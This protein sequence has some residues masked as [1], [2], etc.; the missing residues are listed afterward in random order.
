[1]YTISRFNIYFLI[2]I[3]PL[4]PIIKEH[5]L[6]LGNIIEGGILLG[7]FLN[8]I[9]CKSASGWKISVHKKTFLITLLLIIETIFYLSDF[10]DTEVYDVFSASRVFLFYIFLIGNLEKLISEDNIKCDTIAKT[11]A[12]VSILFAV[13]AI[14]QFVIPDVFLSVHAPNITV[15]LRSKSDFIAFSFFNRVFS[16]LND[17]NIFGV[18]S[19]F[20]FFICFKHYRENNNKSPIFLIAIVGNILGVILSQ[21]RTAII[22]IGIFFILQFLLSLFAKKKI[23]PLQL[24]L[25]LLVLSV[26]AYLILINMESVSEFLRVDTILTGNGRVANNVDKVNY[27]IDQE[28]FGLLLGN[29]MGIERDIIFENSY[30]LL[31]YQTGILGFL[32]FIMA[33]IFLLGKSLN[34][35]K[36]LPIVLCYLSAAYV[37]DYILI[38]QI[39]YLVIIAIFIVR[40]SRDRSVVKK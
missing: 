15:D 11:L 12:M 3:Y 4:L 17:P 38:P 14:F 1:M 16:F 5:S 28:L 35:I 32:L 40:Y 33:S 23:K 34:T 26:F 27:L 22:L 6:I 36:M 9:I 18:F 31:I 8:L 30:L 24:F 19:A 10:F 25:I 7:L 39:T 13:G 20:C 29:G 21:S 37:G 2:F